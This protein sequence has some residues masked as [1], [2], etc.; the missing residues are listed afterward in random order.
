MIVYVWYYMYVDC[1]PFIIMLQMANII[2][3]TTLYIIHDIKM[4]NST[5]LH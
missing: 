1:V 3:F 2:S 5:I 4:N